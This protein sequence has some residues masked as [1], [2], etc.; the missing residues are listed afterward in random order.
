VANDKRTI[1]RPVVLA[2]SFARESICQRLIVIRVI[3]VSPN[4]KPV[5]GVDR[6]ST[7]LRNTEA[8]GTPKR[9]GHNSRSASGLEDVR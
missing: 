2:E 1:L 8:T 4:V 5:T 6:R 3:R 7:T 9:Y